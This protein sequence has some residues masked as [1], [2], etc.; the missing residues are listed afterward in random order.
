M[1]EGN[2][3]R[4]GKLH[5]LDWLAVFSGL[6]SV[7]EFTFAAWTVYCLTV[8][9][10][11]RESHLLFRIVIWRQNCMDAWAQAYTTCGFFFICFH[12]VAVFHDAPC[13][14]EDKTQNKFPVWSENRKT[15]S[16][17]SF[18]MR[19]KESGGGDSKSASAIILSI[20]YEAAVHIIW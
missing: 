20:S 5:A 4:Y 8:Q 16:S 14:H 11:N 1:T 7:P 10:K 2:F 15:S 17:L 6:R 13:T 18:A 3:G 19:C 9:C 12:S